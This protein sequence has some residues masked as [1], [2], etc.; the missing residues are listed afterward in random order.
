MVVRFN[1]FLILKTFIFGPD[2]PP[3]DP[4]VKQK[5]PKR[6]SNKKPVV[7]P[8]VVKRPPEIKRPEEKAGPADFVVIEL[9]GEYLNIPIDRSDRQT[10]CLMCDERGVRVKTS[11]YVD[12]SKIAELLVEKSAWIRKVLSQRKSETDFVGE[13]RKKIFEEHL[14]PWYGYYR[15]FEVVEQ[16]TRVPTTDWTIR[17]IRIGVPKGKLN[18][19]AEVEKSLL[20]FLKAASMRY[21]KEKLE[22]KLQT[23][24][25]TTRPFKKLKNSSAKTR[26]GSCTSDGTIFLNWRLVFT[27]EE[28]AD[29]VICHEVAHLSVLNH[30]HKFWNKVESYCPEYK[31]IESRLK[32]IHIR[33][34]PL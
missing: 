25:K 29:Y 11:Y 1:P 22:E 31:R 18:D 33:T 27:D 28:I 4:P 19:P 24:G 12:E 32:K 23:V 14:V 30:S 5:P 34:M 2:D 6:K 9:D 26:W 13:M 3:E 17:P 21:L 7:K 20:A 16:R 10:T 15:S 8:P